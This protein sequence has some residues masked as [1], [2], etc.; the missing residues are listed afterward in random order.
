MRGGKEKFVGAVAIL[1][2]TCDANACD[3][4]GRTPL[5]L[6]L[7]NQPVFVFPL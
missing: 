3:L 7:T 2:V 1:V 6:I 5:I 4:G